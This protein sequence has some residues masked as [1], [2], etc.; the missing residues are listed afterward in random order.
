MI[1]YFPIKPWRINLQIENS[2]LG[3]SVCKNQKD[4]FV[5]MFNLQFTK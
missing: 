4:I 5:V 2:N 3:F 1:N